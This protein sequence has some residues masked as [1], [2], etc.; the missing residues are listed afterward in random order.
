MTVRSWVFEAL[1]TIGGTGAGLRE[2][3][4][5]MDENRFEELAVDTIEAALEQL[6]ADGR[7]ERDGTRWRLASRTS[8][9]DALR[10]LFGQ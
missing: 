1:E 3:Q 4:R 7:V 8:K 10:K 5:H 9:E 6:V 2:I